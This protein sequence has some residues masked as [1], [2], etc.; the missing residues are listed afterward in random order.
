MK[1]W[2]NSLQKIPCR[3][4]WNKVQT[5]YQYKATYI[6]HYLKGWSWSLHD[7]ITSRLATMASYK[8]QYC[9]PHPF[10]RICPDLAPSSQLS[11]ASPPHRLGFPGYCSGL[12]PLVQESSRLPS[13]PRRDWRSNSLKQLNW[14]QA[15][16]GIDKPKVLFTETLD[17]MTRR[18]FS[19]FGGSNLHK[20]YISLLWFPLQPL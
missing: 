7:I 13:Q 16:L 9:K 20:K 4:W 11:F 12:E 6:V 2:I 10:P 1:F 14:L 17:F 19:R 18:Y 8:P 3:W 15:A 5:I